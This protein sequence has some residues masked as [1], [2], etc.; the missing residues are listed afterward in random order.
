MA[1]KKRN[2]AVTRALENAEG[3]ERPVEP[4]D[5]EAPLWREP[6]RNLAGRRATFRGCRTFHK[7]HRKASGNWP[8]RGSFSRPRCWTRWRM[9]RLPMRRKSLPEKFPKTMYRSNTSRRIRTCRKSRRPHCGLRTAGGHACVASIRPP[10]PRLQ[11]S[12]W[13]IRTHSGEGSP[14]PVPPLSSPP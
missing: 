11:A 2:P 8:R 3:V 1:R 6:A 12:K 10:G 14:G 4:F 9:H 7:Q 13:M 5:R